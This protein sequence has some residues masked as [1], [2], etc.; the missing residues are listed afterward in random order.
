MAF[1]KIRQEMTE[2]LEAINN[3]T[4]E[5]QSNYEAIL[6]LQSKIEHLSERLD[7]LTLMLNPHFSQIS[8]NLNNMERELFLI[9]YH[10]DKPLSSHDFSHKTGLPLETIEHSIESLISKGIPLI[11]VSDIE[12]SKN[13]YILDPIFKDLQSRKNIINI[14]SLN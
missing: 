12:K 2:H 8:P 6:E 1:K 10:S 7:N 5:I 13:T 9:L 11:V 4:N 14:D 3:N